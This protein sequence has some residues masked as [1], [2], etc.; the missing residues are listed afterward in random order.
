MSGRA[1]LGAEFTIVDLL[2]VG[3]KLRDRGIIK[4]TPCGKVTAFERLKIVLALP[5]RRT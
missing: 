1:I 5:L 2:S 4:F 3:G